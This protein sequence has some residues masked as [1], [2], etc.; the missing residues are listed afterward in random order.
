MKKL[1]IF[2]ALCVE[3][4][5][6]AAENPLLVGYRY[7]AK[8][9]NAAFKDF[10]AA[11]GQTFYNAKAGDLSWYSRACSAMNSAASFCCWR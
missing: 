7:S 11:C 4:P 6:F 9:E 5:A 1:F 2:L 10:S 3:T 8:Q